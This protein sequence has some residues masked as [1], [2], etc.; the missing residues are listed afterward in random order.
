[1]SSYV[2]PARPG[3]PHHTFEVELDGARYGFSLRWNSRDPAWYFSV[4]DAAGT[5]LLGER[6]VVV[7]VPLFARTADVR[8]P[9]GELEAVDTS[10]EDREAGLDDL[11]ARVILLYTDV[12]D[13]PLAG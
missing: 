6:K 1:M 13:V 2:L 5:R 7:G 3:V 8:L 12:A 9:P 10:G 4:M 11:G